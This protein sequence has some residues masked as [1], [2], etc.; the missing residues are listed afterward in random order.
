MFRAIRSLCSFF[1]RVVFFI[2][3]LIGCIVGVLFLKERH[4]EKEVLDE[5]SELEK[6]QKQ[7]EDN[8]G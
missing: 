3:F 1:F 8:E 5:L 6:E 7:K 2:I 4:T